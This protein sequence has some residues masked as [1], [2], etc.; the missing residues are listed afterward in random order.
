MALRIRFFGGGTDYREY[1]EREG[2]AVLGVTIDK[3][4]YVSVNKLSDFFE[5]KIRVGY[6]KAELVNDVNDITI[7]AEIPAQKGTYIL[8]RF[9]NTDIH[10]MNKWAISRHIDRIIELYKE[11]TCQEAT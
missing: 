10:I 6:S 2:G 5:Y 11:I 7:Y 3:Y 1:F 8:T 9:K 4:T